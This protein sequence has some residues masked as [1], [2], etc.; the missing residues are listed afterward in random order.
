[1]VSNIHIHTHASAGIERCA[2]IE[3]GLEIGLRKGKLGRDS[4]G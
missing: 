4:V 1:M 2:N 3:I